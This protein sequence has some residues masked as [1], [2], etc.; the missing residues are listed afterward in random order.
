MITATSS[1]DGPAFTVSATVNGLAIY[2]DNWAVIDL[3]E[4]DPSRRR[5]FID[6]LQSGADLL[7]SVT[8]AAE[9]IGPEG[10]SFDTVKSFLNQLGPHWFP[11]ELN[12][13][14]VVE[15]EMNGA[16]RS[17]SCASRDFMDAY[18]RDRIKDFAPRSG[19][20]IDLSEDFFRLGAVLDWVAPQR[21]SIREL[22]AEFDG[23]VKDSTSRTRI[24]YERNPLPP[25]P[26]NPSKPATFALRNLVRTLIIESKTHRVKKGDGLDF[27]HAVIASAFANF[28]TLDKHWKRRIEGLPKPNGLARIYSGPELDKMV[29]DIGKLR[30]QIDA[31]F[32]D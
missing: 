17:E 9:L 14:K 26:F 10:E 8:N 29:T 3:A 30:G 11:V 16:S 18:F 21:D 1:I 28:A 19:K 32:G 24:K 27:C 4:G 20:I 13:F 15:R 12:P 7:F 2:L 22:S 31:A 23:I 6:A 25:T 5:R